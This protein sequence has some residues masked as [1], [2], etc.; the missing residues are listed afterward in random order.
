MAQTFDETG[1]GLCAFTFAM[2]AG[3]LTVME[4]LSQAVRQVIAPL[5]MTTAASGV[6][7]GPKAATGNPFHFTHWPADW[8]S[9]YAAKDF[10]LADPVPRW[11]RNSGQ[12]LTWSELFVILPK[13]DRGRRVIEAA[14]QFGLTEGMIV[15]M[16]SCDN[17]LGLISFGG[18]RGP[19]V[20]AEQA[21]L[22]IVGRAAFA[23]ADRIEHGGGRGRASPILSAR[24]I[25]CLV[26]LVHGHSDSEIG[27]LLGLSV[28]TV[29]FHLG[30]AREK[31]H[32]T[33]RTHLAALAVA[34]GFVV[35]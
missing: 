12:A 21:F 17:S 28:R 29:R 19:L 26:L 1:L 8:V 35:L 25:E 11:A 13:R 6:V 5:G 15:P 18:A 31:F 14:A 2:E 30:N 23:A 34:Q 24:E 22:T 9:L 16:R 10:L 7:S 27:Q 3:R 33:S 32:A 4:D 20:P